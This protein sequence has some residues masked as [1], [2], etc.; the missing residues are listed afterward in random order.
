MMILTDVLEPLSIFKQQA[1]RRRKKMVINDVL[2]PMSTSSKKT[3]K[4]K[5]KEKKR[6]KKG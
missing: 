2:E 5:E 3:N 4:N 6:M 1:K